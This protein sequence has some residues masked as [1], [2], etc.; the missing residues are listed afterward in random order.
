MLIEMEP[1]V[2]KSFSLKTSRVHSKKVVTYR[3]RLKICK[4]PSKFPF[5]CYFSRNGKTGL[6]SHFRF[7]CIKSF[8]DGFQSMSVHMNKSKKHYNILQ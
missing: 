6:V 3:K 7:S 4:K 2:E 8:E 1:R 5:P